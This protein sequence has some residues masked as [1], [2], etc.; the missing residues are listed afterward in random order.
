MC[1]GAT[2]QELERT[3]HPVRLEALADQLG[4]NHDPSA[5][6]ALLWRLGGSIVQDDPDVEDA[7]CGAL[8]SLAV[9]RP[10]GNQRFVFRARHELTEDTVSR[11]RELGGV[12]P[13]AVLP[14]SLTSQPG[15]VR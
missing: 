4:A 14:A 1:A 11:L 2:I 13:D 6:G 9:M 3:T 7:V 12:D 5:I 10:V 8:V 15:G